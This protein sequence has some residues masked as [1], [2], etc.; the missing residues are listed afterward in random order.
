MRLKNKTVYLAVFFI[1]VLLTAVS[2]SIGT[3][4]YTNEQMISIK[5]MDAAGEIN[6]DIEVTDDTP[7]DVFFSFTNINENISSDK[8]E[9]SGQQISINGR[10]FDAPIRLSLDVPEEELD[11]LQAFINETSRELNNSLKS[12]EPVRDIFTVAASPVLDT[13]G[14]SDS[15]T[16][17]GSN[18]VA[19]TENA[20]C[21]AVFGPILT[22]YG[23][24]TLNI[25]VED[26]S[27]GSYITAEMVTAMGDA[28]LKTGLDN[29]IYD[30]VTTIIGEE[31]GPHGYSNLIQP[32]DEIT[33]YLTDIYD[34]ASTTGGVVGYF[35]PV[36]N[37]TSSDG[38]Y[39]YSN[40]RIMFVVDSVLY[41]ISSDDG[42]DSNS[43]WSITDF[44]PRVVFSTLSHE[45]QHM[46]H[47]YQK[48]LLRAGEPTE[49]WIDEMCSMLV[50][51][52]L[53]D[54]LGIEGPRGVAA[55]D[56]S[57]GSPGNTLGRLPYFNEYLTRSV[58]AKD[59]FVIEDYYVAYALGAYLARNYGGAGFINRVV[60][61]EYTDKEAIVYAVTEYTGDEELS[62]E[63]LLERWG[64]AIFLSDKTDAPEGYRYNTGDWLST[65]INSADYNLGAINLYNYD[66][67]PQ[68][69][70]SSSGFTSLSP[71]SNLYFL[72][73]EDITGSGSWDITVPEDVRLTVILK[74]SE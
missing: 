61:S 13:V 63:R 29:D 68:Y 39:A 51:D 18:D 19:A 3:L 27:W 24:K 15:F 33:I 57:A 36:H 73:G 11:S 52:V 72:A 53:A 42:Y 10:S 60:Q 50:E 12:S 21:R 16:V 46:I 48:T 6:Y 47:F 25:W 2:C 66:P 26:D 23:S 7:V 22:I 41:S 1:V 28:F 32:D 38:G 9:V 71:G 31:W 4:Q 30:W 8:P 56:G 20:H 5:H 49:T 34:D 59:D 44:W 37:F 65:A 70:E 55:A 74:A 17:I 40:E 67:A 54:K 14:S 45:F 35:W 64:A 58:Y 43:D 69:A 62:F